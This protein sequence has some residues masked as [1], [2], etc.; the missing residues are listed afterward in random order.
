MTKEAI[1]HLSDVLKA[2]SEGETIQY[3]NNGQWFDFLEEELENE[4][5]SSFEFRIKPEPKLRP[6]K[7]KMEFIHALKEHGPY[8]KRNKE[9]CTE[10]H[11]PVDIGVETAYF[12]DGHH[13]N[14]EELMG[15]IWC[16]GTPCGILEDE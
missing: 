15:W 13:F 11:F 1:K 9:E 4:H 6:Y 16:D 12:S 7:D 8:L 5:L 10:F 14:W 3:L 2:Y